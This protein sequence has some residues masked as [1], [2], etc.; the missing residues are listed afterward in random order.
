MTT[1]VNHVTIRQSQYLFQ[2]IYT[3]PLP[4]RYEHLCYLRSTLETLR[5]I[6][7]AHCTHSWAPHVKVLLSRTN[8]HGIVLRSLLCIQ[9]LPDCISRPPWAHHVAVRCCCKMLCKMTLICKKWVHS[10]LLEH[11]PNP[12]L[13]APSVF[14]P[15]V[16]CQT[17]G[18]LLIWSFKSC[19]QELGIVPRTPGSRI[20]CST[21]E[22]LPPQALR[23][24]GCCSHSGLPNL[25]WPQFSQ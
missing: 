23:A 13:S 17:H 8:M 7:L 1:P 2:F 4:L 20:R 22:L 21:T 16:H 3:C 15:Y 9:V 12:Y 10:L 24:C 25:H 18:I 5:F 11:S 6:V 14:L 19:L